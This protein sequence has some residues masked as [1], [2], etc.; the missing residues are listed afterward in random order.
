MPP[1]FFFSFLTLSLVSNN[2]VAE[3][4]LEHP[5]LLLPPLKYWD[6][7]AGTFVPGLVF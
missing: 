6:D 7:K 4:C 1:P 5:I 2:Y 3:A